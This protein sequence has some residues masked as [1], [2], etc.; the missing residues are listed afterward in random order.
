MKKLKWRNRIKTMEKKKC[1]HV[2]AGRP[3]KLMRNYSS[4]IKVNMESKFSLRKN[5]E[6]TLFQYFKYLFIDSSGDLSEVLKRLVS[7][8]V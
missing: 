8:G 4:T 2:I 3:S 5:K 1:L 6:F 7:L